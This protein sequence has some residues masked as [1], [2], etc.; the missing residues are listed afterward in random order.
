MTD[1]LTRQRLH[2][3]LSNEVVDSEFFKWWIANTSCDQGYL[4][5]SMRSAERDKV[6]E[7]YLK[8]KAVGPNG[9][10]FLLASRFFSLNDV[11]PQMDLKGFYEIIKNQYPMPLGN[12]IDLLRDCG[13]P[14]KQIGEK[15]ITEEHIT[16]TEEGVVILVRAKNGGHRVA[17]AFEGLYHNTEPGHSKFWELSYIGGNTPYRATWGRIE[18]YPNIMEKKDYT[19]QEAFE[20]ARKKR[21][22][23]YIKQQ[24]TT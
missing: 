13:I 3:A 22:K 10:A 5:G 15:G 24:L 6:Y 7:A 16:G 20:L 2:G 1:L 18:N 12:L 9:I 4:G 21:A 14:V 23:G 19:E 17:K 8:S 11:Y